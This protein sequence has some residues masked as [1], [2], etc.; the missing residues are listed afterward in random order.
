M[1]ALAKDETLPGCRFLASEAFI[2]EKERVPDASELASK[3][4]EILFRSKAFGNVRWLL[5]HGLNSDYSRSRRSA[6]HVF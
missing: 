2:A 4:L 1:I 6:R 5:A 3:Y